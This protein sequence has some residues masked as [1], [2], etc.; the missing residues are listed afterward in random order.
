LL[1]FSG[2]LVLP[3]LIQSWT[4]SL[5]PAVWEDL[6]SVP[7]AMDALRASLLPPGLDGARLARAALALAAFGAVAVV[8]VLAEIA[9]LDSAQLGDEEP[10]R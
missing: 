1:R 5:V 3:M 8:V 2:I 4:S 10:G 7:S 9:A 6:L